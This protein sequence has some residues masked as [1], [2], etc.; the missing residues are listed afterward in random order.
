[1]MTPGSERIADAGDGRIVAKQPLNVDEFRP[2]L[3]EEIPDFVLD[4]ESL[5]SQLENSADSSDLQS[6]SG[7]PMHFDSFEDLIDYYNPG[8]IGEIDI[9]EFNF[10]MP[11][12]GQLF[13]NAPL[14]PYSRHWSGA[15]EENLIMGIPGA[16]IERWL[17]ENGKSASSEL[18]RYLQGNSE[19][20][21][22]QD[23]SEGIPNMYLFES[24]PEANGTDMISELREIIRQMGAVPLQPSDPA[25]VGI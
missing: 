20:R 13:L 5:I 12:Q 4:L 21:S 1:M 3:S 8:R 22:Y 17:D 23:G 2:G 19:S 18:Q 7:E 9:Q 11:Q 25:T 15:G 6:T 16:E 14:E 10:P 24:A